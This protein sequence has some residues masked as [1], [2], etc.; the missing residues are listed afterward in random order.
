MHQQKGKCGRSPFTYGPSALVVVVVA[1]HVAVGLHRHAVSHGVYGVNAA[2]F[3]AAVE[4]VL[5]VD[6]L[7]RLR[8]RIDHQGEH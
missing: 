7:H 1:A 5:A 2:E 8:E 4:D 3:V 6:R